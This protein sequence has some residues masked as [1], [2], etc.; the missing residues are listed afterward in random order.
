MIKL[1][2]VGDVD[3]TRSFQQG[4]HW[5]FRAGTEP[6]SQ[7]V[8]DGFGQTAHRDRTEFLPVVCL[9]AAVGDAAQRH[10]FIQHRVEN[11]V[12]ITRR[13]VDDL[14]DLGGCGLLFEC[15][16]GLGDESRFSIAMTACA[17]K[18]SS[19]AISCG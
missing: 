1:R 4:P 14:Q 8:G 10:G 19:S 18:F 6:L 11:G 15:F 13:R 7:T 17:A 12:E 9:K 5:V 16:A 2:Q 3:E